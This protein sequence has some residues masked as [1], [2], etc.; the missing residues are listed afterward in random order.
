V[1]RE[2]GGTHCA[3]HLGDDVIV[4][5]LRRISIPMG[6][7]AEDQGIV[8]EAASRVAE[9]CVAMC[10]QFGSVAFHVIFQHYLGSHSPIYPLF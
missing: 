9:P 5:R 7:L 10:W 4:V 1:S 6:E 8:V 2:H 3:E